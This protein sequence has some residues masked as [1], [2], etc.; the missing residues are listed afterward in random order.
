V[1]DLTLAIEVSNPSCEA[2]VAIGS[3]A[4]G[5][6]GTEPIHAGDGRH[7]DLITAIDRLT[8]R[9]SITPD[10]LGRIAVSIG[11]GGYTA[12]RIAI[13]TTKMLC[14][15]LRAACIAVPT[16]LVAAR[17]VGAP[18]PFAILLASKDDTAFATVF[19]DPDAPREPGR[20]ITAADLPHLGIAAVI[21]DRFIPN[22]IAAAAAERRLPIHPPR[23]DPGAC[24][25]LSFDLD[26]IDPIALAPHYPRE[27]EAVTKWRQ[28]HGR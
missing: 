12:L 8:R 4:R 16:P 10:A 9:L 7:D 28:R 24:L 5:T 22:A 23:F 14:E 26:P 13:A 6:L 20:L 17:R 18:S 21:A 15:S 27:P 19:T 2:G 3:P 11:P 1:P 25:E